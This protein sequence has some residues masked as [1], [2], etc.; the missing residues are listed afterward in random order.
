[1]NCLN[2]RPPPPSTSAT[3][4]LS[5]ISFQM[6]RVISSPSSSTTGFF[7]LIFL[8][9]EDAILRCPIAVSRVVA[10]AGAKL[11]VGRTVVGGFAPQVGGARDLVAKLQLVGRVSLAKLARAGR[12]T[13]EVVGRMMG[14]YGETVGAITSG[15]AE[16]TKNGRPRTPWY[17][18]AAQM[19]SGLVPGDR[20]TCSKVGSAG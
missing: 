9:L 19:A 18:S 4:T 5:L 7:T 1:M 11:A 2:Q 17:L 3:H 14:I 12:S 20:L 6:M 10:R 16:S 15:K 8:M 13:E